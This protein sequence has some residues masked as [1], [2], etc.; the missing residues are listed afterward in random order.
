MEIFGGGKRV[1]VV[2]DKATLK[3]T[4]D[5]EKLAKM[6]FA[7]LLEADNLMGAPQEIRA[8]FEAVQTLENG[9]TK[10]ELGDKE[11]QGVNAE[12]YSLPDSRA[13]SMALQSVNL[14][15]LV[16][17]RNVD[18][19]MSTAHL[20]FSIEVQIGEKKNLRYWIVDHCFNQLWATFEA[21]QRVLLPKTSGETD[22]ADRVN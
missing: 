7:V 13:V 9:I 21:A 6:R 5:G 16:V 18:K 22:I 10:V 14:T 15:D 4:K 1:N 2:F 17:E 8:G 12:F 3:Q 19:G 20:F 11:M